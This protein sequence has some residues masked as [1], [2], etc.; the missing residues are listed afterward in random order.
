MTVGVSRHLLVWLAIS[1]DLDELIA[2][3][4]S[5]LQIIGSFLL[6]LQSAQL[7]VRR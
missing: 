3:R 7:G 4:Q 6:Y 2:V 1:E 5:Q